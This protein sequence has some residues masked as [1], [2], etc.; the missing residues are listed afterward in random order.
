M[1]RIGEGP[2]RLYPHGSKPDKREALT[3]VGLATGDTRE[4]DGKHGPVIVPVKA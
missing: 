3:R 2:R 1:F 4:L